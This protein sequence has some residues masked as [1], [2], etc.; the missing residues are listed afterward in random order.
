MLATRMSRPFASFMHS[1]DFPG[2]P[3][4]DLHQ[5]EDQVLEV[6]GSMKQVHLTGVN[7][8]GQDTP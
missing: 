4:Q 7:A 6:S 8:Q 3:C 2:V 5:A 1:L